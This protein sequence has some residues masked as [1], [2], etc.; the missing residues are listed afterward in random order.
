MGRDPKPAKT[1]AKK[2]EA[3][4]REQQTATSE[5]L[6]VIGRSPGDIQP[7]FD[8]I[9]QSARCCAAPT[10]VSSCGTTANCFI[11]VRRHTPPEG[12]QVI[13][14][15]FP[16]DQEDRGYWTRTHPMPELCRTSWRSDLGEES[17]WS[18][19]DVH[20]YATSTSWG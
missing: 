14:S 1:K 16:S 19:G 20:L 12:L 13:R 7:V 17:A 4:G 9:A 2:R 11:S 10:S 6:G 18:G 8:A 15:L 3:E 5:I